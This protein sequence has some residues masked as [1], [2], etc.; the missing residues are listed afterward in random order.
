MLFNSYQF[1][2]LFL[3]VVLVVCFILASASGAW[4]AQLWLTAASLFFYASWSL[5]YLPL[6]IVSITF[7]YA[8]SVFMIRSSSNAARSFLLITA[9]VIDLALLGYYK[10]ANF[11]SNILS[12]TIGVDFSLPAILLPLGI[13]FYTFQ[14][15]TL[16]ADM[17][18][19]VDGE[20][21]Q[22]HHFFL[23][24]TFFPHLIAGPIVH[25]RE[26]MPQFERA[27]Y[28]LRWPNLAIGGSLFVIGLFKK[29][30]L[31]DG[32]AAYVS[33][34]YISASAGHRLT[35]LSAWAAAFGFILQMYFDFSGYSEMALGLARM[36]GI[37]LPI[38]FNSPLKASSIT[39][40]WSRWHMTLTRFLGEYVNMPLMIWFT[41]RRK[42]AGKSGIGGPQVTIGALFNIVALPSLTTMFLA[43]LW[44]GAGYQFLVWGALNGFYISVNQVWRFVNPR[45]WKDRTCY[46]RVMGPVGFLMTLFAVV[47]AIPFFRSDSLT[48]AFNVFGG[49]FFQNGVALPEAIANRAPGL[50]DNL[51]RLGIVFEPASLS[52]LINEW[53]WVGALL[54]IALLAPNAIE[55]FR[56][57]EPV[58]SLPPTISEE[59]STAAGALKRWVVWSPR[60]S[61]AIA[62]AVFGVMGILALTRASAF[63]YWQF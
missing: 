42:M 32:I 29:V 38:N 41:R 14:Q 11:F 7:N 36:V 35:F 33:P 58:V 57:Y 60:P 16:L 56:N 23:F 25:H 10:Y 51:T 15:L 59:R 8:I 3:P 13:S 6:L 45:F 62:M 49:L 63:L 12:T 28:R 37:K 18:S 24:V 1:I 22:F 40:H 34:L 27:D 46:S 55:I 5:S 52:N 17:K 53:L 39:D 26:M 54:S 21:P 31:A 47:V 20:S 30:V 43:G 61:W 50:A 2:F 48:T 19:R 9:V 44:H 4:A